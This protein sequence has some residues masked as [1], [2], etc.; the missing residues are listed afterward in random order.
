M[1]IHIKSLG[2]TLIELVM[3]I[4]ILGILSAVA[5]PKFMGLIDDADRAAMRG[6]IGALASAVVMNYGVCQTGNTL[7]CYANSSTATLGTETGNF[8]GTLLN[9]SSVI[10]LINLDEGLR[11]AQRYLISSN[12]DGTAD[13]AAWSN[14][15]NPQTGDTNTCHIY[16]RKTV[17]TAGTNSTPLASAIIGSGTG[18]TSF[19]GDSRAN[20][21]Y[22][23]F[24]VVI[25]TTF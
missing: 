19:I 23:Q 10:D 1:H 17:G 6:V 18:D 21:A 12:R 14:P 3:V 24:T 8:K 11:F 2:F 5:T 22:I 25:P 20:T 15:A 16:K 13:T 4:V 9:C 7:K